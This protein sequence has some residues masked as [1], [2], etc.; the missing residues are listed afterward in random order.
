MRLDFDACLLLLLGA[1]LLDAAFGDPDY[2]LHPIRL[3]GHVSIALE[4]RL[5]GLGLDGRLGGLVHMLAMASVSL[6][7]WYLVH[8]G[9]QVVHPLLPWVWD[10]AWAYSLLCTR[11]LLDHGRRVLADLN[12]LALARERVA[13]LVSR[14]T[15]RLDRAGVV[16]ASIESMSENFT[17]GVLTPL[18]ALALFG[19]P[20]LILVKVVSSLDSMVGYRNARYGRFGWAAAR[21]DDLMHWVPA[22]LSVPLIA[23]AAALLGEHWRQVSSAARAWHAVLDSPNSGWSEAAAAGALRVR[24][25]G[26]SWYHGERVER[27]WIGAGDWPAELDGD[28]LRRALRLIG[29]A[30]LLA[31]VVALFLSIALPS[32]ACILG[33]ERL[34]TGD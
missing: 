24:L 19:L 25:A 4:R 23:A 2:R 26:P 17:D 31:V 28:A 15:E 3:F 9:L 8:R 10:L 33:G 1:V 18:W 30:S 5:F 12:D 6:A 27:P 16:R 21:L 34:G 29:V 7:C 11:D 13:W 20:G 32:E 22:R 14:D